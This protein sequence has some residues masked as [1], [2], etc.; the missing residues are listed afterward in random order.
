MKRNIPKD[1][2]LLRLLNVS[3]VQT[4]IVRNR[5]VTKKILRKDGFATFA[6]T[7]DTQMRAKYDET[8]LMM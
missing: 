4:K 3:L 8:S 2:N 7:I 6:F 5:R 1:T